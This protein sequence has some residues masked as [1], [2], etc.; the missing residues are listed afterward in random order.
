M[1]HTGFYSISLGSEGVLRDVAARI[2]R[3][4][5]GSL[6]PSSSGLRFQGISWV[7]PPSVIVGYYS[8]NMAIYSP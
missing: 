6:A 8:Y 5:F 7:L 2:W 4:G 3:L 1:C